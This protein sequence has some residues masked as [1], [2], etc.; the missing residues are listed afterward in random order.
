LD[1]EALFCTY[2]RKA[3]PSSL[4][5]IDRFVSAFEH[6]AWDYIGI[7]AVVAHRS[8]HKISSAYLR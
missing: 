8:Q 5:R 1:L 6:A 4:I 2:D 3:G 7:T